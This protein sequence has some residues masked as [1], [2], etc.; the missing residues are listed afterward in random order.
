MSVEAFLVELAELK[1]TL[2]IESG[3]LKYVAPPGVMTQALRERLVEHKAA[4][5]TLLTRVPEEAP[6]P[7]ELAPSSSLQSDAI[8]EA[9]AY[10]DLLQVQGCYVR[11]YAGGQCGLTVPGSWDDAQFESVAQG[12]ALRDAILRR[13]I[14]CSPGQPTPVDQDMENADERKVA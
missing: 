11:Y 2:S 14:P 13:L 3:N 6:A 4:L 5:I 9:V 10:L 7:V 8:T 12:V 1:V